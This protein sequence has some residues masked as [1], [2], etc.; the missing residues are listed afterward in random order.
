LQTKATYPAEPMGQR[1]RRK[2]DTASGDTGIAHERRDWIVVALLIAAT[3]AVF[4]GVATHEFIA[5]D[6]DTYITKNSMVQAG[7]SW[8]SLKW[9]FTTFACGYWQPLTWISHMI[10]W[11]LYGLNAGHHLLTNLALHTV[12]T[13]LLFLA[14]KDMSGQMWRSAVVAALFAVHPL[15]VESVAWA[16]ER[17]DVL[18]GFFCMLTLWLYGGYVRDPSARKRYLVLASFA[19]GLLAKPM[20]V[21]LPVLLLLL[22]YWPLH[23]LSRNSVLEKLPFFAFSA[24]SVVVT[25]FGGVSSDA[26][27]PLAGLS[28]L[29]RL[30]NAVMSYA[31]YLRQTVWPAELAVYYPFRP[32]PLA[33][34]AAIALVLVL[35]TAGVIA[36]KRRHPWLLTG[37][38]WY[39]VSLVPVIGI[40]QV[41]GQARADRFTY[42]PLVGI[43]MAVVWEVAG[44]VDRRV[45]WR[46]AAAC[47][48]AVLLLGFG[49]V[50]HAQVGLWKSSVVLFE[51]ALAVTTDNDMIEN[52][53]GSVLLDAGKVDEAVTHFSN[54]ARIRPDYTDAQL[55]LGLALGR[56][57]KLEEA[58]AAYDNALKLHPDG[59]DIYFGRGVALART[60]RFAEALADF[61]KTARLDPGYFQAHANAGL[62]LMKLGRQAEAIPHFREA[63]R[64][65]PGSAQ[66]HNNLGD[67]LAS[68]GLYEEARQQFLLALQIDPGLQPARRNLERL[69]PAPSTPRPRP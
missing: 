7:L 9:A 8:T 39:G 58:L 47:G 28:V 5:L 35:A 1:E 63:A 37:W 33:S 43:F 52:N 10:D 50:A 31:Q 56:Q 42:I 45:V 2:R 3:V 15:H 48:T 53:L 21:S 24:G 18:S 41:G 64:L 27:K 17:K 49:W 62:V 19:L 20:L 34:A 40:I 66:A 57:G 38:L 60:G 14:L 36:V 32:V 68:T 59:A 23:R 51:H 25:W 30:G 12:A 55:N 11:Q 4:A 44:L 22:D 16:A 26:V 54:A 46:R 67:A 6:D 61:E 13:L 69:P 29:A 65:N